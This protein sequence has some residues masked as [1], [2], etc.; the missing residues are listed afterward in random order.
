MAPQFEQ[1]SIKLVAG[2]SEKLKDT[3]GRLITTVT[4]EPITDEDKSVFE[5][6]GRNKQ[7]DLLLMMQNSP[8][9]SLAE[10]AEALG[11]LN[12][13]GKPNKNMSQRIM[14]GLAKDKLVAKN[15]REQYELTKKGFAA[16]ERIEASRSAPHPAQDLFDKLRRK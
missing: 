5:D 15:R 16:V 10:Y 1:F 6:I 14:T 8:G 9:L 7:D 12:K 3:K 13:N 2:T 11:W 4:A